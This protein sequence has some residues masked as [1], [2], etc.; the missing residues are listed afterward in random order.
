[1]F[2]LDLANDFLDQI[3]DGDDPV[4]PRIFIQHHRQMN[5][6][7]SHVGQHVQRTARLRN[8]DR[9][10]HQH[11]PVSRRRIT[12]GQIGE[13][14]LDVNHPDHPVQRF[15]IDRHPAVAMFGKQGHQ[16]V[17]LR[18]GGHGNDLAARDRH[19]IGVMLAE[20]QE[21]AQH[22]QFDRGKIA[23]PFAGA[24]RSAL[25]LVFVN[26]LFKLGAQRL[27]AAFTFEKAS[28]HMPEAATVRFSLAGFP[29]SVVGHRPL[30]I[31]LV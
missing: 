23:F 4:H 11:G 12:A 27:P 13:D 16:F 3:L 21:I 24:V 28:N 17:P 22:L 7:G 2:I 9:L 8:I 18:T 25:F 15:A 19:I 30:L 6:P 10:A 31:P 5:S 26:G 1:M 20:M 29:I 14:I